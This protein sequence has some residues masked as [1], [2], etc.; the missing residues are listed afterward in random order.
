[1]PAV[2]RIGDADVVHC[3][4]MSRAVGSSD[5]FVNGEYPSYIGSYLEKRGWM[6]KFEEGDKELLK[7]TVDYLAFSYYRSNTLSEGSFDNDDRPYID[8]IDEHVIKNPYLEATEWGWEKDAIGFRWT[9]Q[10]MYQRH[11]MP[12]F[13]LEN[14]MGAREELDENEEINDDYRIE[15][16]RNHIK[17]MKN[18]ILD[19]GVECLGYVTWGPIDIPSSSCQMAKRYGFVYVNRTE[20]DLKD[21]RR[22]PKKSFK[23]VA[24]AFKSNGEDLD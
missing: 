4:G 9:M 7:Y 2:T 23:W 8:I 14:G 13:I 15:Y 24:K 5:V 19:D 17:E 10:E 1:M 20:K 12:L 6:P 16:H 22:I 3:S 11:H 21:L 18:A